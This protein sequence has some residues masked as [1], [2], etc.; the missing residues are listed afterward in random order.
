MFSRKIL[1]IRLDKLYRINSIIFRFYRITCQE[2]DS[3][4]VFFLRLRMSLL[5]MLNKIRMRMKF[6]KEPQR[7]GWKVFKTIRFKRVKHNLLFK[8]VFFFITVLNTILFVLFYDPTLWWLFDFFFFYTRF[9]F[10]FITHV[11]I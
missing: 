5:K 2:T 6:K 1:K 7:Q 11:L 3:W 10:Y 9:I 8:H 4:A